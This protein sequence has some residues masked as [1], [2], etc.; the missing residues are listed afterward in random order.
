MT[1]KPSH[2]TLTIVAPV[3][4]ER[5]VIEQ[6]VAAIKSQIEGLNPRYAANLLLVVD[7]SSDGTEAVITEMCRHD[8]QISAIFLSKRFG[9]Q[10]SLIAGIDHCQSDYCLM[11]DSDLQH[12][13]ALIPRLLELAE[14]GNDIVQTIRIDKL[15]NP[16]RKAM[17]TI[18][19]SLLNK[20]TE[21]EITASGADFRLISRKVVE[22]LRNDI[23]ER[24]M[25]LRGMI[26]WL[27]FKCTYLEFEVQKRAAGRSKYSMRRLLQ[28]ATTG[29]VSFSNKPL[30]VAMY[31]GFFFSSIAF[32]LTAW[33]LISWLL[34]D[35]LPSGWTT[36]ATMLSLF[37]G[38][39]LLF[40]GVI[41]EYLGFIFEEVKGRPRYIVDEK[42]NL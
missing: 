19:Y 8:P 38:V 39:Q 18:F 35:K 20:L 37:S 1:D 33:I 2:K 7:R 24:S 27:G 32:L 31:V 9:H 30:K 17:S 16:T 13:P 28:F 3:Y 14:E 42:H 40:L 5:N 10:N 41:G 11:M 29:I 36:L 12:P 34:H 25:F 21:V 4:N 6:F 26:G 22:V 23:G 15:T